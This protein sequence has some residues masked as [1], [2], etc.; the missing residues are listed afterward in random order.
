MNIRAIIYATVVTVGLGYM[1]ASIADDL[2][3]LPEVKTQNGVAYLSGGIG[4]DQV[5]AMK[6]AAKDYTLMLTCAIKNTGEYLADVKVNITDKSGASVLDTVTDGPILLAR[7]APGQYRLSAD[8]DGDTVEKTVNIT[9]NHTFKLN[10]YW[11]EQQAK[12]Q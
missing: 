7:L 2:N 1:G 4:S 5:I 3:V 12:E 11:P 8:S 10:L 6:A 9:A